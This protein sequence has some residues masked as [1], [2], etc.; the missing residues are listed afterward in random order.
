[1]GAA[2]HPVVGDQKL[3]PKPSRKP[4]QPKNFPANPIVDSTKTK[5]NKE[6]K[7]IGDSNKENYPIFLA[8]PTIEPLDTSLAEE[9]SAI[10][11]RI[12]KL[13]LDKERTE[14]MLKERDAV[15]DLQMKELEFRGEI[16]KKHEIE[17]DRLYRLNQLHSQ[18]MR[19]SPIRSLR[20]KEQGKRAP[21]AQSHV[22][23]AEGREESVGE[24]TSEEL[25]LSSS[26][27][28]KPVTE[29]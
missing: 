28:S 24:N 11:K 7:G 15:L 16:Q 2:K 22:F 5:P 12:E 10:R 20:E 9:L 27:S 1:M 18:T 3:R 14:K 25:S 4:L 21:K 26:S 17:V 23:K 8:P 13:R 29:K 6:W 19:I